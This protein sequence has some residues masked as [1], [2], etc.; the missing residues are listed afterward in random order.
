MPKKTHKYRNQ[1]DVPV[2]G[3]ELTHVVR[4]QEFD[5]FASSINSSTF[6]SGGKVGQVLVTDSTGKAVWKFLIITHNG[7]ICKLEFVDIL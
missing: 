1:F 5:I 6:P 7:V 3:T 2:K 4:K